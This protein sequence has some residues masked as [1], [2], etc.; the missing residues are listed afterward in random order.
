MKHIALLCLFLPTPLAA[1]G[2]DTR[3]VGKLRIGAK[4]GCTATL[5]EQDLVLSAA[6]CV[7]WKNTKTGSEAEKIVFRVS[8][9]LGALGQEYVGK[10]LA[11]HPVYNFPGLSWAKRLS[12]DIAL[13]RLKEKVPSG[14]AT[15][16]ALVDP[17]VKPESGFLISFRGGTTRAR[18]RSCPLLDQQDGVLKLGC[19]VGGGESGSPYLIVHNEELFVSGVL[20]ASSN[21]K[22]QQLGFAAELNSGLPA[23]LE[24]FDRLE[25]N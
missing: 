25:G 12:R 17:S 8:T 15:P 10:H 21:E 16:I 3:G 14:V 11:I 22:R 20:S 13:I 5:I 7:A 6:H 18:Q 2:L 4:G 23:M 24:A 9:K 1:E 19:E